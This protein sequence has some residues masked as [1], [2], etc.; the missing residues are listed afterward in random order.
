MLKND[1]FR[2][3]HIGFNAGQRVTY[4]HTNVF[5]MVNA[6]RIFNYKI[7]QM[8]ESGHTYDIYIRKI[9]NK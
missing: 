5:K 3:S 8:F 2:D 6:L 7:A 9:E 4:I 1:K